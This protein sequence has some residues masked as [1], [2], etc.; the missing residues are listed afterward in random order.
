[1]KFRKSPSTRTAV[2]CLGLPPYKSTPHGTENFSC[3]L[4]MT[5]AAKYFDSVVSCLQKVVAEPNHD[6]LARKKD[7]DGLQLLFLTQ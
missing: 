3:T 2:F 4:L 5:V 6:C 7:A 1:M